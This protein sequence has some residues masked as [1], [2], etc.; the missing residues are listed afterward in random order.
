M[1]QT[2]AFIT[3]SW[4]NIL[5]REQIVENFDGDTKRET[6]FSRVLFLD[7][8]RLQRLLEVSYNIC[9]RLKELYFMIH[10]LWKRI[11]GDLNWNLIWVEDNIEWLQANT[12]HLQ[13]NKLNCAC[14]L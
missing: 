12:D 1:P 5:Y 2:G 4:G 13:P 10:S 9:L 6:C 11:N 7:L 3:S 14:Y 8:F